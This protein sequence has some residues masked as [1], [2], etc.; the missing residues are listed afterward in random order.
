[1]KAAVR[2][3]FAFTL[4][5]SS[6]ASRPASA[7]RAW[8]QSGPP[9]A[10]ALAVDPGDSRRVFAAVPSPDVATSEIFLSAASG[11]SWRDVGSAGLSITEMAA[12][13]SGAIYAAGFENQPGDLPVS[14]AAVWK[15][16]D[17]GASWRA[18]YRSGFCNNVQIL[19]ASPVDPPAAYLGDNV[20]CHGFGGSLFGSVDGSATWNDVSPPLP[21][22]PPL[23]DFQPVAGFA[24]AP[25]NQQV[26][27]LLQRGAWR[28]EDAGAS[29]M[30]IADPLDGLGIDFGFDSLAV[31]AVS[32]GLV[33][34][35]A[36]HQVVR[37]LDSGATWQATPLSGD[38]RQLRTDPS[39]PDFVAAR[40]E[41]VVFVSFDRGMTWR[42]LSPV[43]VPINDLAVGGGGIYVATG[44][45][46]LTFHDV[47]VIPPVRA[48]PG[49]VNR[50]SGA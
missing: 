19:A 15:S 29:W 8:T 12:G 11:A 16:V 17:S 34:A 38:I 25:S 10:S 7:G 37:S 49:A 21:A 14:I 42:A 9:G 50:K 1:M 26:L 30:P 23:E 40:S 31:D 45:G 28:S 46:I 32:S 6:L 47:S 35:I 20:I 3:G 5:V 2:L 22:D 24:I 27:Y 39:V 18:A 36:G 33:Y 41:S 48:L 43:G 4:L 13:P 44:S